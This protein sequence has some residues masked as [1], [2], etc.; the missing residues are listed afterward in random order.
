MKWMLAAAAMFAATQAHAQ[1]D[2]VQNIYA[3]LASGVRAEYEAQL[4][5]LPPPG[6]GMPDDVLEKNKALVKVFA[7]NKAVLFAVCAADAERDRSPLAER[8][9]SSMNLV[10]RTC[11]EIKLGALQKFGQRVAYADLF[12]PE[13][14]ASCGE[15]S[16]LPEQEKA[17]KPYDFLFLDEPRVYDFDR[18]NECLMKP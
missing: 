10:L 5:S 12:F 9:P 3:S 6:A 14:I 8:V 18:Y 16:R 17:M 1:D 15:A 13:R 2:L 4:A 11:I 7:Y